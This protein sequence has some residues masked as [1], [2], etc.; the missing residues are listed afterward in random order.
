MHAPGRPKSRGTHATT[1]SG[2]GAF[3]A[4]SL[5]GRVEGES[6]G[7]SFAVPADTPPLPRVND[8]SPERADLVQRGIHVRDG[9]V[10]ERYPVPRSRAPGVQ[11]ERRAVFAR[12]P[13]APLVAGTVHQLHPQKPSP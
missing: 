6:E 12:L 11:T 7:T 3:E 9:E 13:A 8:L 10:G 5:V 2:K 4:T 1:R